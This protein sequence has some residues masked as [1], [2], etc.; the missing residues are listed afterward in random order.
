[1]AN[2][3]NRLLKPYRN[4][5][6]KDVIGEF[7][8]DYT[9][10]AGYFV[11][12]TTN[13]LDSDKFY[14]SD[15]VGQN[16]DGVYNN[17]F[18]SPKIVSKAGAGDPAAAILGL[19]IEGTASEDAHGNTVNGFGH[20]ERWA[21][22]NGYVPTGKPAQI[23][24]RGLFEVSTDI[25]NGTPAPGS[26]VVVG[27]GGTWTIVDPDNMVATETGKLLVGKCL[28]TASTRQSSAQFLVNL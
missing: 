1:M 14:S 10:Q 22:A 24:T 6:P 19:T 9:G 15:K 11:K 27:A 8:T 4:Y 25:I 26:G 13:D 18:Q 3:N 12:V 20:A 17:I 28:S 23:V 5:D 2:F 16:F 7:R 21:E